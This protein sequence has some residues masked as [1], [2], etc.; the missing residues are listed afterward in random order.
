MIAADAS[1]EKVDAAVVIVIGGG[2][3]H[4]E[5]FAAKPGGFGDIFEDALTPIPVQAIPPRRVR[6]RKARLSG[7]VGEE[8]VDP[9]V[10]VIVEGRDP[11][12]HGLDLVL[13]RSRAIAQNGIDAAAR[14]Y[15]LKGDGRGVGIQRT[16][17]DED[18]EAWPTTITHALHCTTL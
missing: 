8:D 18:R 1:D 12:R 14:A 4:A 13:L 11:A 5:A 15:V 3:A 6:L 16:G 10:A 9:S 2:C 7:A 17:E